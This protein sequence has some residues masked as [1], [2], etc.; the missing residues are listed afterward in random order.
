MTP[1][2]AYEKT[3]LTEYKDPGDDPKWLPKYDKPP[4]RLVALFTFN[5]Q[6]QQVEYAGA[7]L[8]G[9]VA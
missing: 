9:E 2:D 4:T 8:S 1:E 5:Q 6:T 7:E 3:P